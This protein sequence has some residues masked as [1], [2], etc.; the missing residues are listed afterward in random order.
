MLHTSVSYTFTLTLDKSNTS[1]PITT[2]FELAQGPG[3]AQRLM[4]WRLEWNPTP[5]RSILFEEGSLHK[6]IESIPSCCSALPDSGKV[7][8]TIS[9]EQTAP[10]QAPQHKFEHSRP[11]ARGYGSWV[12][13][14]PNISGDW[15][16]E[17]C[18]VN[19]KE[20]FDNFQK[21][22]TSRLELSVTVQIGEDER[23][24]HH[25]TDRCMEE[26]RVMSDKIDSLQKQY[27]ETRLRQYAHDV[28]FVFS[29]SGRTLFA[30]SKTL[31]SRSSYYQDVLT[32]GFSESQKIISSECNEHDHEH[33]NSTPCKEEWHTLHIDEDDPDTF[34]TYATALTWLSTDLINFS[35]EDPFRTLSTAEAIYR[36]ADQLCLDDLSALALDALHASLTPTN[37]VT[38]LFS[39]LSRDFAAI[40]QLCVGYCVKNWC[41]PM[42]EEVKGFIAQG[43][44]L[45]IGA[46]EAMDVM[47]ALSARLFESPRRT[48]TE[49]D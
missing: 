49:D 48:P 25:A 16:I 44:C 34:E 39:I 5:P 46:L 33:T 1:T 35:V 26:H 32:S 41:S 21:S 24:S 36:L 31:C 18:K 8:A 30:N 3:H 45:E 28:R 13:E 11:I 10:A 20:M 37:A 47:A 42:L 43:D 27:R 6:N 38:A 22:E 15:G 14:K 17:R 12:R 9:I 7:Y 2:R 29:P 40:R 19:C 4:Q 23:A